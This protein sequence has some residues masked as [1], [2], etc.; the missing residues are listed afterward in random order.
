MI[1]IEVN[2]GGVCFFVGLLDVIG[3]VGFFW[4]YYLGEYGRR[5][6]FWILYRE[7][8]EDIVNRRDVGFNI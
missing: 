5:M 7:R 6:E 8:G 2:K 3:C 1:C 4:G